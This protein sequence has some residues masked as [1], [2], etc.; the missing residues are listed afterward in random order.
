MESRI[1]M[2]D[3]FGTE[4]QKGEASGN[5]GTERAKLRSEGI[6]KVD[7]LVKALLAM[8]EEGPT[9]EGCSTETNGVPLDIGFSESSQS[10]LQWLQHV[11][12]V[13][14]N[15]DKK[16]VSPPPG[17][18]A[19]NLLKWARS[20]QVLFYNEIIAKSF[21]VFREHN[22]LQGELEDENRRIFAALKKLE[23]RSHSP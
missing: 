4:N 5:R 18:G 15:I 20:H 23:T 17:S 8:A 10:P 12:W 19:I 13:H 9:V 2:T 16:E 21:W 22:A 11:I 14:E 7:D 6:S 1:E 3:S